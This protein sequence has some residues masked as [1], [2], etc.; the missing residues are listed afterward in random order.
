MNIVATVG[1]SDYWSDFFS[2]FG[3]GYRL[4]ETTNEVSGNDSD[5]I[6]YTQPLED[7]NSL[8]AQINHIDS[9]YLVL[10]C[11]QCEFSIANAIKR[12]IKIEIA[13]EH[14]VEK[15]NQIVSFYKQNRK[16]VKLFNIEH[17]LENPKSLEV[18]GDKFGLLNIS[19]H[20]FSVSRDM[21]L[22][23][24]SQYVRQNNELQELN[25]ELTACSIPLQDDIDIVLDCQHVLKIYRD[26][27]SEALKNT[28][29]ISH[30]FHQVKEGENRI[31]TLK[32]RLERGQN[33]VSLEKERYEAQV[34]KLQKNYETAESKTQKIEFQL[35]N[36]ISEF[37]E[38]RIA[39]ESLLENEKL[40]SALI[41]DQ[42]AQ[43]QD[44]LESYF[45]QN[46]KLNSE[47]LELNNNLQ[48]KNSKIQTL[49]DKI[50]SV[51]KELKLSQSNLK[52][53]INELK[54]TRK[55]LNDFTKTHESKM[56]SNA[57]QRAQ[58]SHLILAKKLEAAKFES[59]IE[60]LKLEKNVLEHKLSQSVSSLEGLKSSTLWKSF[61]P[62]RK[63]A[64]VV[65]KVDRKK[66][67][68]EREKGILLTSSY[69]NSQWYVE[70]YPDVAALGVNPAEHYLKFG[71]KE[72]RIPSPDFD[73]N[74]YLKRYPDVAERG[75]NP[76]VHYIQFGINEGRTASPKLLEKI[77]KETPNG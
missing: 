29:T 53:N 75:E 70:S 21:E 77:T 63:L 69:F 6:I 14:W 61:E 5:N 9:G 39:L 73:G 60:K 37:D 13:A 41:I 71:A 56:A 20:S 58:D 18:A 44:E 22:L 8:S 47:L 34:V 52:D 4:L 7:L 12:G 74:W 50:L 40:G 45:I 16:K 31:N 28:E 33:Q 72:G 26:K 32:T 57:K 55:R 38:K 3:E 19:P 11:Q 10:F 62:I 46:A 24:S 67:K 49:D 76:L 66:A 30:L 43:V 68:L 64:D 2:L 15:T 25:T 36:S 48:E 27:N 17:A 42:L 54:K 35:R 51:E 23:L 59:R 65:S 1:N